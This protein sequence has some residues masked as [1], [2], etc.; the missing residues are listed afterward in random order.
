MLIKLYQIY[1]TQAVQFDHVFLLHDAQKIFAEK[2]IQNRSKEENVPNRQT[3][4]FALS[5]FSMTYE[6]L[7]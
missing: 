1:I 7:Y 4:G 5:T 3:R 2:I 6:Q